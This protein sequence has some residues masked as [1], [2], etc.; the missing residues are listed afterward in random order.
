MEVIYRPGRKSSVPVR[1]RDK[2]S[3]HSYRINQGRNL[4]GPGLDLR[5]V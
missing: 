4:Y 5:T 2:Y 3:M 1:K